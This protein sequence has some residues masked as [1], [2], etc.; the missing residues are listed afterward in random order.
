M[1][2]GE[3]AGFTIVATA[4][5]TPVRGEVD[6][7]EDT[8]I[9][10]DAGGAI[11]EVRA[12]GDPEYEAL[13]KA[14]RDRGN[15]VEFGPGRYLLPGLVDLHIHAPQWPQLGTALH[16]PLYDW[17]RD[18]TFP[19]EARYADLAFAD[20][21]YS[22][23]VDTLL[24]NGTT[25]AV[26]FATVHLEATKLLTR[27][28]YER[29]QRGLVGK[30]AMD[31]PDQCPDYY[32]DPSPGAAIDDTWE[33]IEY[34][35]TLDCDG[36]GLVMPVVT[37]RFVPSCTDA[38]LDG[39]GS[40]AAASGCH[41]QTHCSESDWQHGYVIDR[42]G[43]TDSESLE[44]FGLMTRRSV[45][46]HSNFITDGDM[47]RFRATGAGIAHCPLSNIYFANSV[48][49]LRAALDRGLHV[50]LGTDISGGHDPSMLDACRQAVAASRA[51]ED[52]VDPALHSTR[53]GRPGSRIDFAEA[54]WLAT[55]GGGEALDLPIGFF[56]RGQDF[57]AMLID[58]TVADSNLIIWEDLDSLDD[59][60]QKIVYNAA[61]N[62]IRRVWVGGRLVID[63][64]GDRAE[65]VRTVD[66]N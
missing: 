66:K 23:L 27:K 18:H 41:I 14:G 20:R 32:R 19:L 40:V 8:L 25:T 13:K 59:V 15:L 28:C 62:N 46:A 33:L 45:L 65:R 17:L 63:K 64:D 4:M 53:R 55:A 34:V 39:L 47:G 44:A 57:D 38:L 30:V 31:D 22:S 58:T 21:I 48:F 37:P 29:G 49:P 26:Y 50:G 24:A 42:H 9:V 10:V 35:R 3:N 54:F 61:R 5:H 11:A 36:G 52:G 1:M 56:A 6:I 43:R 51:L 7:H 12:P 16:R 60:F 2:I